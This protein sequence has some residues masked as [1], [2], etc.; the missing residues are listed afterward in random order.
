LLDGGI[1]LLLVS[2]GALWVSLR[3]S[4]GLVMNASLGRLQELATVLFCVQMSIAAL[5]L[6]GPAFNTQLGIQFW[7]ITGALFGVTSATA[8]LPHSLRSR[9]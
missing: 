6:T 3:Q 2:L 7:A 1:P 4:Y 5:C 8:A 9:G